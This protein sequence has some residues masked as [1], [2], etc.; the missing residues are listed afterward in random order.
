MSYN[1]IPTQEII[2]ATMHALEANGFNAV[3]V[4]N[5]AE[6]KEKVMELIPEGAEVMQMTSVTLDQA[7]IT[8]E[9]NQSGRFNA[10]KPKL[11]AMDRETQG[12]EMAKLGAAPD[13][14]VGS[15]H[16][17]TQ[18]GKVLIASLTGSQLPGY[19]YGSEQVIWVVGVNKIVNNLDEGMKRIYEYVLPQ[20]S[21]RAHK[22]YGVPGSA[23]NKLLIMNAEKPG[24]VTVVLV[25]ETAGF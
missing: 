21:E 2:Q 15:V 12:R 16:A 1:Q 22:A 5:L 7:G 20:E 17:I 11:F 8:A 13:Y 19:V 25:N 23:V 4:D 14:S 6:A 9:I 18:D 3:L 24:R 10:V